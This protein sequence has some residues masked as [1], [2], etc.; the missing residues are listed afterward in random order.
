MMSTRKPG[1]IAL[2]TV[3]V[4]GSIFKGTK[5][6]CKIAGTV[7]KIIY[8]I[9]VQKYAIAFWEGLSTEKNAERKRNE[10]ILSTTRSNNKK[11]IGF[12]F[13]LTLQ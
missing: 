10:T 6:F 12:V 5:V 11:S 8:M 2:M 4:L 7:G 3:H 1:R 13:Q 9:P